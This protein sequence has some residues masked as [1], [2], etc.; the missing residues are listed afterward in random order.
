MEIALDASRSEAVAEVAASSDASPGERVELFGISIDAVRIDE[1]V[2]QLTRWCSAGD[3]GHCRYVVTPNVNHIVQLQRNAALREAYA[4]ASL[5]VADGWPI[6]AASRRLG[7][8]LPE[9]VAGSDLAP[10]MFDRGLSDRPLKVFL[11]GGGAGVPQSAAENVSRQWP[12]VEIVGA[13]SPS[14]SFTAD[15]GEQDEAIAMINDAEPH[16][17]VVGLGAPKQEIWLQANHRRLK[18]RVAIAGGATIDFLAGEQTRAPRWVQRARLEWVFRIATNPRRLAG[19]YLHDGLRFPWIVA[20]E[21]I[22]THATC[23]RVI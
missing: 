23:A 7:Q 4:D 11:L 21:A 12:G 15:R 9:R 22:K 20:R 14:F 18:A 8:S 1:A 16:L 6:V 3:G 2:D 19:R 17:L 13:L 10:A 5:V